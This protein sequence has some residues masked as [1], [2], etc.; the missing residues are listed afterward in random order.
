MKE[1]TKK[2]VKRLPKALR[3]QRG[4]LPGLMP[5]WGG[6]TEPP[7]GMVNW[8]KTP[9]AGLND[10]D[11]LT[12]WPD[13]GSFNLDLSP[14]ITAPY[15]STTTYANNGI[16]AV[17]WVPGLRKLSVVASAAFQALTSASLYIVARA[18]NQ[19]MTADGNWGLIDVNDSSDGTLITYPSNGTSEATANWLAGA[20][21]TVRHNA[22]ENANTFATEPFILG[23][24]SETNNYKVRLNGA[25]IFTT[26][27]N[28]FET[29]SG[30]D[31]IAMGY[32]SSIGGD[33][34]WNGDIYECL[35]YDH[36][37]DAGEITQLEAYL[38]ARHGIPVTTPLA[39]H[40]TNLEVWLDASQL[41][42]TNNDPVSSWTDESGNGE[43]YTASGAT[44]STYR[45]TGV[46]ING[47]PVV[48]F[49]AT[50]P[51]YLK[52]TTMDSTGWGYATIIIVGRI[53]TDPPAVGSKT[54]LYRFNASDNENAFPWTDS[55]IYMGTWSAGR[56][57]TGNPT[58]ALTSP[59]I[60]SVGMVN[61]FV[62]NKIYMVK[63]NQRM[64]YNSG[65]FTFQ[66]TAAGTETLIG[67]S[68]A[69]YGS[70][71][72]GVIA[73]VLIYSGHLS[74]MDRD[75]TIHYLKNKY[76]ISY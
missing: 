51:N 32:M 42:L 22:G 71:Y 5:A 73:E 18:E 9:I 70:C 56:I 64:Q 20:F 28:T 75:V 15:Y 6:V 33:Y 37:L 29:R 72:D 67:S 14:N 44:R 1:L 26:G 50:V 23:M 60:F 19:P 65:N 24:L 36:V 62:A 25:Q 48:S 76:G 47:L 30:F 3:N 74:G 43:H 31:N 13:D 7:P 52:N 66:G 27:T 21:S 11:T 34:D 45:D 17:H 61:D 16:P 40:M 59:F 35:I 4:F 54:G 39:P 41:G 55:S 69:A 49:D 57:S 68:S 63:V 8:W 2:F 38:T 12:T 46:T 10:T 53:N 58:F